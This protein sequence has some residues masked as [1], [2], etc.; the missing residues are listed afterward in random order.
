MLTFLLFTASSAA[1][2]AVE[3]TL[4]EKMQ[5]QLDIGS[6]L[7]G[8]ITLHS[9]GKDAFVLALQ[10][11]Q[12]VELQIRGIKSGEQSHYYFYQEG[13]NENQIG[14]TEILNDG[15]RLFLRSDL[16]PN[17]VFSAPKAD[18]LTDLLTAPEGGNPSVASMIF[19]WL[20]LD[21][22]E[23]DSLKGAVSDTLYVE[24][25]KWA[26]S[27]VSVSSVRTL[28][29][30]T[31]VF[32]MNYSIPMADLKEEIVR[33]LI[34]FIQSDAG[35]T[36]AD[37]MMN[38]EQKAVFANPNLDYFYMEALSALNNDYDLIYTKTVSTLGAAV[39]SSMELPLDEEKTKYQTLLI[40][41]NGGLVSYTLR[42]DD[43]QVTLLIGSEL[44]LSQIDGASAWIMVRPAP[45]AENGE[46]SVYR[47]VRADITHS[48]QVS[49]DEEARD[50]LRESWVFQMVRD[51]SR[52]PEGE[53]PENYP[54]ESPVHLQVDLHYFSKYSQSSPT[55][56]EFSAEASGENYVLSAAGQ[57]KTA[58]PWVFSP[59]A[60]EN[61]TDVTSLNGEA[62][63]LKLAEYL[64]SAAENLIP[65]EKQEEEAAASEENGQ[66]SE[67]SSAAAE[68]GEPSVSEAEEQESGEPS[69]SGTEEQENGD[70]SAEEKNAEENPASEQGSD[71]E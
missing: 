62:L 18:V 38:A 24:L 54:E 20:Q 58:S 15:N 7:K 46:N 48:S 31:S 25:E 26:A 6:G 68:S 22:S 34:G 23:R 71:N 1:Y 41:E 35:K 2:G 27:Y 53:N 61:A 66:E 70:A 56:L 69:V 14:L 40:E 63:T 17:E 42:G 45:N 12:D 21:P 36:F 47:A 3:Y 57:L 44:D 43:L 60:T 29:N 39:S 9:E 8:N 19:R 10:P 50:H 64:A 28:D 16:L 30:G 13:E 49:A 52:L 59:F 33:L 4:P 51:V 55:T 5:K 32:D 11:F 65:A 37:K 67:N